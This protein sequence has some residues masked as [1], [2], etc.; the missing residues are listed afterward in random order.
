MSQCCDA[1]GNCQL[2]HNCPSTLGKRPAPAAPE[3]KADKGHIPYGYLAVLITAL[4]AAYLVSLI[5]I[6]V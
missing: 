3:Y 4:W 1:N 6:H 2:S 5:P